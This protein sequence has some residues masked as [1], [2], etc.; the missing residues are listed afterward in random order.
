VQPSEKKPLRRRK[1]KKKRKRKK[2]KKKKGKFAEARDGASFAGK[3]RTP[4]E[5]LSSLPKKKKKK[6]G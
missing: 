5:N 2:K 1:E 4:K 3:S 6:E